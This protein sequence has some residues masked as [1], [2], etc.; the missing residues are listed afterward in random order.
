MELTETAIAPAIKIKNLLFATDFSPASEAAFPFAVAISR[1]YAS[2]LHVAHVLPLDGLVMSSAS[3]EPAWVG[4][5]YE[6][7]HTVAEN[8]MHDLAARL[9]DLSYET[10]VCSGE[11]WEALS[12]VI[13]A[14]QIDFLVAGTHGRTGVSKFVMGSC[15]EEIL[16][17]APCPV[18]TVGP[19]VTGEPAQ[20]NAEIRLRNV[21]YATDF[22]S[23]AQAAG[24]MAFSLARE[25]QAQLTLLHVIEG[26]AEPKHQQI[27]IARRRL[28]EIVSGHEEFTSPANLLVEHGSAAERIL[29][30]ATEQHA[31]LIVLGIRPHEHIGTVTHFP[32]S[33]IP[34]VVASANCPV[35]TVRG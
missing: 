9:G 29:D 2:T 30:V 13:S 24:P 32:W 35:L 34:R 21:V 23:C 22:T 16:R 25:F 7:A 8:K 1:R 15:A 12:T 20:G 33:T 18:L 4:M 6:T 10:W 19:Y 11:R 14:K 3:L 5:A 27:Q 31:D 26:H 17:K 28:E